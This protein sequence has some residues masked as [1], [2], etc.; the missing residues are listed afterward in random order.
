MHMFVTYMNF[1]TGVSWGGA[2]G[3][4]PP[5]KKFGGDLATP[6]VSAK[7]MHSSQ[8]KPPQLPVAGG[9]H[10]SHP[11]P[12]L[13]LRR[14]CLQ[15][16]R[17]GSGACMQAKPWQIPLCWCSQDLWR[18]VAGGLRLGESPPPLPPE[19]HNVYATVPECI[20]TSFVSG[21]QKIQNSHHVLWWEYS[22]VLN[23]IPVL[24]E[25]AVSVPEEVIAG[26]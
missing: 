12:R 22:L 3:F 4:K 11:T 9:S 5:S 1:W 18:G 25:V 26:N 10:D 7:C 8:A 16:S 20:L 13:P 21:T 6:G 15:A 14:G 17:K 24:F 19:N 2:G 23:W